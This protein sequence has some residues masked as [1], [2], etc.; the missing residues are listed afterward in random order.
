M[1]IEVDCPKCGER[2]VVHS[3]RT[4]HHETVMEL[5]CPKCLHREMAVMCAKKEK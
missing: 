4:V 3:E 5:S 2:M 1:R